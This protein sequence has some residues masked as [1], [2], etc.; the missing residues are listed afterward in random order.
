MKENKRIIYISIVICLITLC[1][2]VYLQ[3]YVGS[4]IAQY[5]SGI[6]LNIFAGAIMLVA[7]SG[8]YYFVERRKVL[9][10]LMDEC[11]KIR[12]LFN[13]IE[14]LDEYSV[15]TLEQYKAF[16]K[17]TTSNLND[18]QIEEMYKQYVESNKE[19]KYHN[20]E[21]VMQ[22][23]LVVANY[24]FTY[25]YTLYDRIDFL[26]GKK[27]KHQ[28]YRQIFEYTKNMTN[29]IREKAFHFNE[30]FNAQRGNK[31]VNFGFV[32]ELQEKVFYYEGK[33]LSDGSDWE[34]DLSNKSWFH[35][36]D[37]IQNKQYV[38][39]NKVVE[40]YNNVFDELG[41]I[42][43]FDKKY[44]SL[45]KK[46][47]KQAKVIQNGF[48]DK[49]Y[50][51]VINANKT[52]HKELFDFLYNYNSLM[53]KI[54][55]NFNGMPNTKE[56]F[57]IVPAF[58]EILK[59]YQACVI[60]LEY[61]MPE[62]CESILRSIYDLKFQML[63][64][65]EDTYNFQ[66]LFKKTF[67]KE[68]DK[69]NYIEKNSLYNYVSKD[70]VDKS[71]EVFEQTIQGLEK[72]KCAPDT[73]KMCEDL[74][75]KDEYLFYSLLCNYTHQS[76][77]VICGLNI[78]NEIDVLP[79]YKDVDY[80]GLRVCSSVDLVIDKIIKKYASHLSDEYEMLV[81]ECKSLFKKI[82]RNKP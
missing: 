64:V 49:Q 19:K 14:Y 37:I 20:M 41:K 12:N 3:F 38:I 67:I 16:Y 34:N 29:A 77:D 61:G 27:L 76:C 60:M 66:R 33:T 44:N 56:T 2:S 25:F 8:I 1:L 48:L 54:L 5:I 50:R 51:N 40:Y 13:K 74:G 82:R 32:R 22:E 11:L 36:V 62:L 47:N 75:L 55:Y 58:A 63:Y 43:Y 24:D 52:E 71:R 35:S 65:L 18:E 42:A 70:V 26:F 81:K 10:E 72:I 68:I 53:H 73:K 7:T 23:Y 79:N 45:N 39:Y 78:N 46:N 30:Y 31:V 57:Y 21:K 69:L 9:T 4:D 59:L 28:L 15:A 80:I 17:K 6:V